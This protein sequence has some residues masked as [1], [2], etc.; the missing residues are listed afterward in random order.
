MKAWPDISKLLTLSW[1]LRPGTIFA[2]R[3]GVFDPFEQH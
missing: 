2:V 1:R 3:E